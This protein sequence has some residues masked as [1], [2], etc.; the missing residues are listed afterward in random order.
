[1]PLVNTTAIRQLHGFFCS[2]RPNSKSDVF[3]GVLRCLRWGIPLSLGFLL[4]LKGALSSLLQVE[5][6]ENL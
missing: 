3:S 6:G 2:R 4:P 5:N 1:M